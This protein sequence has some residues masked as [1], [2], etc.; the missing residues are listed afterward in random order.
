MCRQI[1]ESC[2][3]FTKKS[4]GSRNGFRLLTAVYVFPANFRKKPAIPSASGRIDLSRFAFFRNTDASVVPFFAVIALPLMAGIGVALDYSN[5]VNQHTQLRQAADSAALFGASAMNEYTAA[6]TKTARQNDFYSQRETRTQEFA[7]SNTFESDGVAVKASFD[8][9]NTVVVVTMTQEFPTVFMKMVGFNSVPLTVSSS[10]NYGRLAPDSQTLVGIVV[11]LSSTMNQTVTDSSRTR[12]SATKLAVNAFFSTLASFPGNLTGT[13]NL[14]TTAAG[15][16]DGLRKY[17]PVSSGYSTV[18]SAISSWSAYGGT[19]SHYGMKY[20]SEQMEPAL[21]REKDTLG[22]VLFLTDGLNLQG[23]SNTYT[24]N[25]CRSLKSRG[26]KI[27]AVSL[28]SYIPPMLTS[29]ASDGAAYTFSTLESA[30]LENFFRTAAKKIGEEASSD[31]VV[32]LTR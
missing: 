10:A 23:S 21:D 17:V 16:N 9:T 27:F 15:F 11:D 3:S 13:A 19:A 28:M 32:R 12:I 31:V 2:D 20:V 14:Q 7:L 8:D 6:A 29:C 30:G 18:Q 26:V 24:I 22:Y 4:A 25:Y 5:A 1:G